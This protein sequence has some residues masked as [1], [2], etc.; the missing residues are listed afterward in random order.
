MQCLAGAGERSREIPPIPKKYH[1]V[2]NDLIEFNLGRVAWTARARF[3]GILQADELIAH[4]HCWNLG[5]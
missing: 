1:T 5:T 3:Q 4:A 2:F